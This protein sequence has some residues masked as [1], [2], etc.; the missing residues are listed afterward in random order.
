MN[1]DKYLH[2]ISLIDSKIKNKTY[3]LETLREIAEGSGIGSGER[4][5]SSGSQQK[6]ADAVIKYADI[7]REI[8]QLKAERR[9][10][11][12][13]IESLPRPCYVVMHDVYIKGFTLIESSRFNGEKDN[14]GKN[15]HA[16]AK[17]E[18]MR[19]LKNG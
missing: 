4:V 9:L 10:F 13:R 6:M 18:L 12:E 11:I 5:Q 7:E 19:M 15:T 1:I 2:D 16:R 14:W 3:E 17:K 8:E